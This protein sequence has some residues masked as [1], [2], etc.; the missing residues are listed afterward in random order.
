MKFI[1]LIILISCT[2]VSNHKIT[3]QMDRSP[4]L[5]R[6]ETDGNYSE[7]IDVMVAFLWPVRIHSDVQRASLRSVLAGS[8]KLK[9][10]Q[11]SY[12]QKKLVLSRAWKKEGCD[13][14]LNSI[15][16]N[17]VPETPFER[18][19]E[20]EEEVFTNERA[21][22]AI[23]GIVEE[24]K[25]HVK[26]AG[27]EWLKTHTDFPEGPV[28]EMNFEESLLSLPVFSPVDEPV[29]YENLPYVLRDSGSYDSLEV[30]FPD[31]VDR[32][33][34]HFDMA[35]QRTPEAM[36]FQGKLFLRKG[37]SRREGIVYWMNPV[38]I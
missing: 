27:G 3:K 26:S 15:C 6:L 2:R 25:A 24:M 19:T 21:L 38:V 16:E 34:W 12:F 1:I 11:D 32:G 18:C 22:P 33:E 17:E 14:V 4:E 5:E 8:R 10:L 37:K 20:L 23:Y 7:K 36:K 13:C 29:S 35:I 31:S 28:S 9:D 30:R